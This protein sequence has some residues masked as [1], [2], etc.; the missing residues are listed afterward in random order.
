MADQTKLLLVADK[1]LQLADDL[2]VLRALAD[3]VKNWDALRQKINGATT[4]EALLTQIIA[5][6]NAAEVEKAFKDLGLGDGYAALK[7]FFGKLGDEVGQVPDKYKQLLNPLDHFAP[8]DAKAV[9]DWAISR[10]D[11]PPTGS[12]QYS[13]TL[14]A[15][16]RVGFNAAAKWPGADP[17]PAKLL[18]IG[19]SGK[20]S[21]G[22]KAK[23]PYSFGAVSGGVSGSTTAAIDY[24]F[25]A[26]NRLYALAAAERLD[27]LANPFE[28]S[29]IWQAFETSDLEGLVIDLAGAANAQFQVSFADAGALA[30]GIPVEIGAMVGVTAG[31]KTAYR[32][33]LR[34]SV[35]PAGGLA[36]RAS[37]TRSR[38][39]ESGLAAS[40]DLTVDVAALTKPVAEAVK[41]A[42]GRWNEALEAIKPFLSPG[43]WLRDHALAEL[44]A[45]L[46][47][48]VADGDLRK[49][50]LADAGGV[51]GAGE[52][53]DSDIVGWLTGKI[54]GAIDQGRTL[55]DGQTNQAVDRVYATLARDLPWVTTAVPATEVKGLIKAQI[56]KVDKALRDAVAELFKRP[57][58][59][60]VDALQA[61]GARV[62]GTLNSFNDKLKAV[63]DLLEKYDGLIQR[64]LKV[65]E[66]AAKSKV[67]AR[68]FIEESRQT[69]TVL[70]AAGDFLA[71]TAGSR[72]VFEDLSRGRLQSLVRL[73]ESDDDVDGFHLDRARSSLKRFSVRSGKQGFEIAFLNIAR[74]KF[75]QLVSTKTTVVVDGLGNVRV[76]LKATLDKVLSTSLSDRKVSFVETSALAFAAAAAERPDLPQP[77]VQIGLSAGYGDKTMSW[78]SVSDFVT[79]LSQ[80]D[81]LPV[82]A[83]EAA[84]GVFQRWSAEAGGSGK[85]NG[86]LSASLDLDPQALRAL[87]RLPQRIGGQLNDDAHHAIVDLAIERLMS[88]GTIKSQKFTSGG[89]L[90]RKFSLA[91]PQ[92]SATDLVLIYRDKLVKRNVEWRIEA[93][94]I[95]NAQNTNYPAAGS[96]MG[97]GS[98]DYFYFLRQAFGVDKLIDLI[99]AMG[100]VYQAPATWTIKDYD[101]AQDRMV[102]ATGFWLLVAENAKYIF[103]AD[104]SKRTATFMRILC[105]LAG[106]PRPGGVRLTMTW[107]KAPGQVLTAAVG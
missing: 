2:A 23:V 106:L 35:A 87:L 29:A 41:T 3:T 16:A 19:A 95:P 57:T 69:E 88:S 26:P 91:P 11:K 101:V 78:S 34:R 76:D 98:G 66:E 42:I 75:E 9:V 96:G 90:L 27:D 59:E 1:A 50:I 63:R 4:A 36:V 83:L 107:R 12:D 18:K 15:E 38:L 77:T 20:V 32:L 68:V 80:A 105:D 94:Q 100:D 58:D 33:T 45:A 64:I 103:E 44:E 47:P 31:L 86:E 39:S 52:I 5:D 92:A 14:G 22:V 56:D 10:S 49:A 99:D 24:Y 65:A 13:L 84:R 89:A 54:T 53:A 67:T 28:L 71:L 74:I 25:N 62:G 21:A 17:A 79:S 102:R 81:L 60:I 70:E 30:E 72:A 55:V 93:R 61:A 73:F 85:I 104:V 82:G 46:K 40:L 8:G 6:L 51:L 43:T 37:L 97:S 48:W 7:G